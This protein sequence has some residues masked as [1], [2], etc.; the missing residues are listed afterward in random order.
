MRKERERKSEGE[1][2]KGRKVLIIL[3]F[4]FK[5]KM[6]LK[7]IYISLAVSVKWCQ[8]FSYCLIT[9]WCSLSPNFTLTQSCCCKML[10]RSVKGK[11]K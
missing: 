11:R 6:S 1:R 5:N 8:S 2:K 7:L 3:S 9:C 10:Q 4:Y